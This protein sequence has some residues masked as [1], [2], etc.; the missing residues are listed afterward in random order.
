MAERSAASVGMC[1]SSL[2]VRW[3]DWPGCLASISRTAF[4][5]CGRGA[6]DRVSAVG[7]HAG[8]EN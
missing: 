8:R 3:S 2:C 5:A 1:M 6:N 7:E 4:G